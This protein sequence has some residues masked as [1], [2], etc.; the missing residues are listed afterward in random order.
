MKF[1]RKSAWKFHACSLYV[2][3]IL[4]CIHNAFMADTPDREQSKRC[5]VSRWNET[6]LTT[7]ILRPIC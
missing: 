1:A 3:Y 7:T 2:A 4:D 5:H 6:L